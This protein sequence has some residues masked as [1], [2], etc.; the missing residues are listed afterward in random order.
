LY[1]SRS[2]GRFM[3][4]KGFTFS[5][6]VAL[7]L[8]LL[9]EAIGLHM[10]IG[11]FLAG[12][13]IREE[14]L[15]EET[16]NKIEDRVYGLSYSFLGPIFFTSLAFHLDFS[17]IQSYSLLGILVFLALAGKFLG[18]SGTARL[19]GF[20]I[21]DAL[22]IGLCMNSRGAVDLIIAS[23]GF[24]KGVIDQSLFS[25]LVAVPF[26]TTAIAI[27]GIR[28]FFQVKKVVHRS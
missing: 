1:I 26:I 24:E 22:M 28:Y 10:I 14:I 5:L 16:F 19:Q 17:A 12:L 20:S 27:F 21:K 25:A 4:K 11:A 13:F 6:I 9:A 18:A 3:K 15:D 23:V 2:F 7:I 8:G